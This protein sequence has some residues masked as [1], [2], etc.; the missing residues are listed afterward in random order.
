[1]IIKIKKDR[2]DWIQVDDPSHDGTSIRVIVA[3]EMGNSLV[4]GCI[5]IRRNVSNKAGG[6]PLVISSGDIGIRDEIVWY[7]RPEFSSLSGALH[8]L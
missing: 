7:I 4:G 8:P 6:S 1:M 5:G 3:E 2:R